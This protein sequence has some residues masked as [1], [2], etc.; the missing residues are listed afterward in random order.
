[1]VHIDEG[2]DLGFHIRRQRK[3]GTQK[4]Y[5]YTKP[6]GGW[7][8]VGSGASRHRGLA[9]QPAETGVAL[10]APSA[11]WIELGE[12]S[13]TFTDT[14]MWA[15]VRSWET[16]ATAVAAS[17]PSGRGWPT[18]KMAAPPCSWPRLP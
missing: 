1:M 7:H 11:S 16:A 4:W 17:V 10:I 18:A 14:R 5:V 15:P 6:C 2:F 9:D 8:R 13:F 12:Q 3:R